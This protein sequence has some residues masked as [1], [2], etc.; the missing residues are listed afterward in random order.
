MVIEVRPVQPENAEPPIEVTLS[1]MVILVRLEQPSKASRP[2]EVTL[3]G[4][5]VFLHPATSVFVDVSII[6]LLPFPSL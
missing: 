4:M 2:I 5:T 6:H 3:S 1:G